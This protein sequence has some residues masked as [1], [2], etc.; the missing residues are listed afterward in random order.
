M[1]R[2]ALGLALFAAA[3]AGACSGGGSTP[4]PPPPVG[5]FSN[6]SLK[7]QYAFSMS[8]QDSGGF[9][10]RVGS[11][12]ADGSGNITAGIEDVNTAF[13]AETLTFTSSKYSIQSDGRGTVNLTN[14]TG[15]LIFSVTL[16]SATQ[17]LMAQTDGIATASG[18]FLLQNSAAFSTTAIANGYVF[19]VSGIDSNNNPD[20]I[21][22]QFVSSG[23]GAITTGVLDEN[24]AA[25]PS[26]AATITNGT[27]QLDATNGPTFGRGAV[28]FTAGG[29][30]FNYIFYM[31]DGS[32]LRMMETNSTALTVGDAMA[33]AN[34]VPTTNAGFTGS[35]AMLIGGASGAG[36][37]ARLGRFTS[38]G[39]GGLTAI[40]LHDNNAGN[41]QSVPKG[42]VSQASYALDSTLPG[43]G[44]GT[45]TFNDSSL[46]TFIFIF[47][48]VSPTQGVIQDN[49]NLIV[50]DGTLLAQT[51]SPFSNTNLAGNYAFN[52]SGISTNNSTL[53]TA[54]EDF[55]GQL[56]LSSSTSSNV[57]GALDLSEFSSNQGVFLNIVLSGGLTISGDGTQSNGFT[58][59]LQTN[60]SSTINF[61]AIPVNPN[62]IFVLTIDN[63]RTT[64]GIMQKQS[65]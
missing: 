39:N 50:A 34:N 38:D 26:G 63:S 35:F 19:D 2:L 58:T 61:K 15:T 6:S 13:A 22:G 29:A 48:M 57:T 36:P 27:Y 54:E 65:P 21:V 49:S 53:V 30:T 11:F 42:T 5:G 62:S 64:A 37:D 12:T 25:V 51:G 33:Q 52:W 60:P 55:V 46:G 31:V 18:T 1:N 23:G 59:T 32:R 14:A 28:A 9:F 44:R 41:F 7:G 47:Y 43:S 40:V 56:A 4:V 24:D 3:F 20:S 17:G 16:I 10:A 8:G 45:A